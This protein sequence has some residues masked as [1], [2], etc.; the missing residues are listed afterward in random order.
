MIKKLLKIAIYVFIGLLVI[1]NLSI[2]GM[3]MVGKEP[4]VF[5]YHIYYIASGSME[6]KIKTGQVIVGKEIDS[7]DLKENM[8]ITFYG[9]KGSLSGKIITHRIIRIYEEDGQKYIVTK[10]DATN[11]EDDPIL[12]SD[13]ISVMKFKIPLAGL[14]IKLISSKLGFFFVILIPFGIILVRQTIDL[15]R[16]INDEESEDTEKLNEN[17][18]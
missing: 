3:K 16:A 11:T 14:L 4:N 17:E 2:L 10:G 6:P 5:G 8:I 9:T 13:V 15:V 7:E 1:V 18:K 12:P